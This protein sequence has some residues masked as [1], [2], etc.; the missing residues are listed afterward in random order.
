MNLNEIKIVADS[1]SDILSLDGI[2]F[3]SAPLSIVTSEKEYIDDDKLNVEEFVKEL[4][5]YNGKSST[6]CPAPGDYLNAFGDA[7]EIIAI[8]ITSGLSGSYNSL[9]LA[10][11]QYEDEYPDRRVYTIDSLSAGPE[12]ALIIYKIKELLLSGMSVSDT[13][14]YIMKYKENTGLVFM[15]ESIKNLA[16]NGR[17]NSILA[18]AIG[19]LGIR[20]IGKA[21][22]KGTLEVLEKKRGENK[23]L[24]AVVSSLY[25]NDYKGGRLFI[26][27][28]NC[29]ETVEK[30]KG[31]IK[32]KYNDA[33]IFIYKLRGLCS[34]YAENGGFLIGFEK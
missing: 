33:E 24:Q 9:C 34:Y 21:S 14:D 32:E 29:A 16:N 4:S 10:K 8:A 12:I 6:S 28:C 2:N 5:Q 19:L 25:E 1:S 27:H 20:L 18:K 11:R 23:A 31:M 17:V 30:I 22:D 26:G 3:Q 15:L 7:K 13:Y